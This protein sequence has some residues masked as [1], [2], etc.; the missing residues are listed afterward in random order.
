[1]G[2]CSN[3]SR[4]FKFAEALLLPCADIPYC[5]DIVL[6]NSDVLLFSRMCGETP[7]LAFKVALHKGQ[8]LSTFLSAKLN[9]LASSCSNKEGSS[10]WIFTD[11]AHLGH[12]TLNSW[13]FQVVLLN[14]T[15]T[16]CSSLPD[17]DKTVSTSRDESWLSGPLYKRVAALC[18][19]LSGALDSSPSPLKDATVKEP[20]V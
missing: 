13:R 2:I 18:M 20:S 10:C 6:A 3:V 12:Y 19:C 8:R 11:T 14:S 4:L 1:M 15:E 7:Q 9:Y 5:K 16:S 17:N